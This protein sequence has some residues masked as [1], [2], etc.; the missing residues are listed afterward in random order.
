MYTD[1]L[2]EYKATC[3]CSETPYL[4]QI[5]GA[6]V[7]KTKIMEVITNGRKKLMNYQSVEFFVA[8]LQKLAKNI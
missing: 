6:K 5:K 2:L 8:G 4:H 1:L 3:A 7:N